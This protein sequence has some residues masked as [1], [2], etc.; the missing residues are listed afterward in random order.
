[1]TARTRTAAFLAAA[2]LALA[3]VLAGCSDNGDEPAADASSTSA[4]A[5]PTD[6]PVPSGPVRTA[7]PVVVVGVGDGPGGCPARDAQTSNS[8]QPSLPMDG[9]DWSEQQDVNK[10]AGTRVGQYVVTGTYDGST[11][12]ATKS[13]PASKAPSDDATHAA[14][15]PLRQYSETDILDIA[16][17]VSSLPGVTGVV[18][19]KDGQVLVDVVYDDGT[20]QDWANMTYG[21]N[22]VVVSST[23][24]DVE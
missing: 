3:P 8:C 7:S 13:V 23:L 4:A 1:V 17:D 14:P 11:F 16:D 12:T 21:E 5:K 2:A 19:L 6:A 24:V 9:W 10:A 15:P 20:L 22:V 18:P